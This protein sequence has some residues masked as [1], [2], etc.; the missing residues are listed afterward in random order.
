LNIVFR[1]SIENL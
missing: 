1:V